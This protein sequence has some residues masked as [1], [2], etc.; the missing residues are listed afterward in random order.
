MA[1]PVV[2]VASREAFE[3][4][5]LGQALLGERLKLQ[6]LLGLPNSLR[7]TDGGCVCI[8]DGAQRERYQQSRCQRDDSD[9]TLH[10]SNSSFFKAGLR[11]G[12]TELPPRRRPAAQRAQPERTVE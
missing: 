2:G 7:P 10:L 5:L 3:L 12:G 1:S 11:A 6:V 9:E 4:Q 8:G